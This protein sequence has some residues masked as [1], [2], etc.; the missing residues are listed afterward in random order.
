MKWILGVLFLQISMLSQANASGCGRYD[1]YRHIATTQFVKNLDIANYSVEAKTDKTITLKDKATGQIVT[2]E[3]EKTERYED[4]KPNQS[5]KETDRFV[6]AF[7]ADDV[8][9]E[10]GNGC[11]PVYRCVTGRLRLQVSNPMKQELTTF[12]YPVINETS[13]YNTI[14]R[15]M[16][17]PLLPVFGNLKLDV[18]SL[19]NDGGEDKDVLNSEQCGYGGW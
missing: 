14:R 10:E 5:S 18:S 13:D 1:D 16:S 8:L 17:A 9:F 4:R 7:T 19:K 6:E 2:L 11:G 15:V 3:W 12:A